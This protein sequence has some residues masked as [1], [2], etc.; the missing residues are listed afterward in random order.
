MGFKSTAFGLALVLLTLGSVGL[1]PATAQASSVFPF[2]LQESSSVLC[3]FSGV[4]FDG[5]Q[6]QQF[7]LQWNQTLTAR[8]PV[9]V[10]FYIAPLPAIQQVWFCDN[11]PMYLYF[12]DGAYGAANWF[13]PLTGAYAVLVLNFMAYPVSGSIS[14]TT[15]NATLSATP[16]GPSAVRWMPQPC[17]F[18]FHC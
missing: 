14:I 17:H 6:G 2:S 13:A 15:A 8:G 11:G 10:D 5:V 16:I 1:A 18:V 9:S 12:N 4:V 3:W 7:T